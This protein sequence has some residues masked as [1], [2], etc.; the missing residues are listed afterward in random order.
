MKKYLPALLFSVAFLCLLMLFLAAIPA[1]YSFIQDLSAVQ[2]TTGFSRELIDRSN[3]AI[4]DYLY[5]FSD[6]LL[7]ENQGK[8]L[9]GAQEVFHMAEVRLL[10]R[11]IF[12]WS[13][14][15]L[16]LSIMLSRFFNTRLLRD[17]LGSSFGLLG[18]LGIASLFFEKAFVLMH[19]IFFDNDLWMFP[20]D[21]NLIALLPQKFFFLFTV[22]LLLLFIG[23]SLLLYIIERRV[24]DSSSRT[25]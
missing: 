7:I 12:L 6:H 24:Y 22:I 10:F 15:L 1:F 20:A 4:R 11:R 17:Q 9:F 18:F 16:V 21:S 3:V 14:A 23:G 25:R 13:I 5:G 2:E 19:G 8:S